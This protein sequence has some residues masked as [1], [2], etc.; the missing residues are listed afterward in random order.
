MV[1]SN[2]SNVPSVA[3]IGITGNQGGSV[4]NALIASS[5]PYRLVGLTRN[6][7]KPS[8]KEWES[9][10]VEM[11]EVTI[12]VGNEDQVRAAFQGID[13]VFVSLFLHIALGSR[14]VS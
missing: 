8:S 9:R 6:L 2:D 13:I 11:K 1:A 4:A 12:A 7:T 5:K 3:I 10:G 14:H